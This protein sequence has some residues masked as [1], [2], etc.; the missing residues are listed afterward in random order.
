[1][2]RRRSA[3]L[4]VEVV[5]TLYWPTPIPPQHMPECGV[6]MAMFA[7][8]PISGPSGRPHY[9]PPGSTTQEICGRDVATIV[10]CTQPKQRSL[11]HGQPSMCAP[12]M[13]APGPR[14]EETKIKPNQ[15]VHI[16][17]RQGFMTKVRRCGGA[18]GAVLHT[19]TQHHASRLRGRQCFGAGEKVTTGPLES[20][21]AT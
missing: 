5:L 10:T 4:L 7:P 13:H 21:L 20:G 8:R 14:T 11:S 18:A 12:K 16:S 1:M 15:T 3:C 2:G 6:W 19:C 9:P 17:G